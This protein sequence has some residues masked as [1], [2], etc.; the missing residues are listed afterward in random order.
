MAINRF[1][2]MRILQAVLLGGIFLIAG[3]SADGSAQIGGYQWKSLYP[4]DVQTVAVPIFGTKDFHRGVEFQVS[5][6]LDH[7]IEAMTPY[8][9]VARDHADTI[10]EGEIVS[11]GTGQSSSSNETGEPQEQLYQITVDFTWKDLRN[12]RILVKRTNFQQAA[13]YY[14]S[15]GETDYDGEQTAAERLAAAIVHELEAAW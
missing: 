7:E 3:C 13:T 11:V 1:N 8:K 5:S 14:P 10:L 15:L 2:L 4:T 12:G 6:A 9:I